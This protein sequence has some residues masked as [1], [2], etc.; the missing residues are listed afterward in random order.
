MEILTNDSQLEAY[1][2]EAYIAPDKPLLADEY[3]GHAI[4]LDVDAVSDGQQVLIGAIM[5]HLE[6]AGIHSGDST[7]FIP[8]QNVSDD[9]LQKVEDWTERIGIGLNIIG[10]FNIHFAICD[11]ELYVLEVNPRG[12]RTFPFVAKSTGIPL[13][14][15]AARV[16]IGAGGYNCP[17][18][19]TMVSDI[20][21]EAF[22]DDEH[23][24]GGYREYW[25]GVD[26]FEGDEGPIEIHF[27]DEVLPGYFWLFPVRDGLVNVGIGMLISEQR[28]QKGRKKSLK[29]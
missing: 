22:R 7:C 19:R 26:G 4:E 5:E 21:E 3:L 15:I 27:I 13:A 2:S 8:P 23:F 10:C 6:E 24:C 18:A 9:I 20:F 28:K 25:E 17:V 11:N 14:R 1:M 12:S 16:T 29:D